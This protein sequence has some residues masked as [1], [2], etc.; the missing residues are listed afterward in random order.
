MRHSL[1]VVRALAFVSVPMITACSTRTLEE[2]T[3]PTGTCVDKTNTRFI[4]CAAQETCTWD[5]SANTVACKSQTDAGAACGNVACES[6]YCS[7]S[8]ASASTCE[9]VGAVVGPLAPPDFPD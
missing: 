5:F 7:C 1:R 4:S 6:P 9:C 3:G 8:D 2:I